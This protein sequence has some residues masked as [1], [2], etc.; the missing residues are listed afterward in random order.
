MREREPGSEADLIV[1]V[2]YGD[3]VARHRLLWPHEEV[4]A[5]LGVV[6]TC[7]TCTVRVDGGEV[8]DT[9][10]VFEI[11]LPPRHQRYPTTLWRGRGVSE[12]VGSKGHSLQQS[13]LGRRN[14]T[15]QFPEHSTP[16]GPQRI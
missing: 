5:G 15:Y 13:W 11:Q 7:T 1:E 10:G 3:E 14:H 4:Q 8:A 16:Q 9:A 2:V 12:L 6:C